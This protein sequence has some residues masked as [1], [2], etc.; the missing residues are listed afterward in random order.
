MTQLAGAVCGGFLFGGDYNPEQWPRN[1][2]PEDVALMKRAG[3]N[4]VVSRLPRGVEAVRRGDRV[5]FL[6]HNE[7][8]VEIRPTTTPGGLTS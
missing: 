1:V 7:L 3:V 6:G 4:P 2:W 5:F 8:T